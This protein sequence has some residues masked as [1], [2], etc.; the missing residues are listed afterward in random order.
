MQTRCIVK[1][2]LRKVHFSGDFLGVLFSQQRLFSTNSTR[3]A[4]NLIKIADFLQTPLVNSHIFTK[5]LVCTLSILDAFS[6]E[7]TLN[8][9]WVF[10]AFSLHF[11]DKLPEWQ[12]A[13]SFRGGGWMSE[14]G[15]DNGSFPK[16][17]PFLDPSRSSKLSSGKHSVPLKPL[18]FVG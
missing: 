1:A 10:G 8:Q 2:R 17:P 7:E 3:K 6:K 9:I 13:V 12:D 15:D 5:H 18:G 16:D 4:V 14:M 11:Q